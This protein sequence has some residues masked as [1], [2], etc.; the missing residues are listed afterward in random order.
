VIV[1][2]NAFSVKSGELKP[3]KGVM[4]V[5]NSVS[6]LEAGGTVREAYVVTDP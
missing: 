5:G 2:Q 4:I 6:R 3:L 1:A